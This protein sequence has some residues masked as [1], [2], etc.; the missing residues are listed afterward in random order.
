MRCGAAARVKKPWRFQRQ[1]WLE[2][3]QRQSVRGQK[4]GT[5][6][7]RAF[8]MPPNHCSPRAGNNR[9]TTTSGIIVHVR[10]AADHT[11]REVP[12]LHVERERVV[13][14][15]AV[16]HGLDAEPAPAARSEERR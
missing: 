11:E 5:K 15:R 14:E 13:V 7:A 10:L 1:P 3:W 12:R 6:G 2:R 16:R 8:A 9:R 4:G